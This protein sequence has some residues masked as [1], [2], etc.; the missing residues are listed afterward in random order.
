MKMGKEVTVWRNLRRTGGFLPFR[1]DFSQTVDSKENLRSSEINDSTVKPADSGEAS[2]MWVKDLCL[3]DKSS[4]FLLIILQ[5]LSERIRKRHY[6][7]IYSPT[8]QLNQAKLG[9]NR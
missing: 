2:Q 3:D 5:S 6:S 8:V 4:F 1:S 7:R 9:G